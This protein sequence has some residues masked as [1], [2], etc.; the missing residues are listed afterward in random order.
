[1][2]LPTPAPLPRIG[3]RGFLLALAPLTRLLRAQQSPPTFSS[4]VKVVNVLATARDKKGQ[5]VTDLKQEEFHLADDGQPQTIRYFAREIDLPLTLG[6]LVDTS[7][8]QRRVLGQERTAS[9]RFLDQV[10]RESK[11]L[12]FVIHFDREAE[13]LQDLTSSRKQ[14]EDALAQLE[15]PQQ[16][17]PQ[18]NRRGSGGGGG[19]PGGGGGYPGGG[20]G[21][22]GYPGGGGGRGGR[23][24]RGPGTVLYDSVLLAS[25]ELMRK[26]HG[27]KALILLTDGVDNGSKVTLERGIEAAQ[28]A[29][30][31]GGMGRGGGYDRPDGK[32]VL[33]R[34]A[35]ETGGGFFQVS[36]KR[37]IDDIYKQIQ[38]EL[39]SQY[40]LGYTPEPASSNAYFHKI[41]LTTTR[42]EV[43]LQARE[44][45][46]PP[47]THDK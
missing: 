2:R 10:L 24:S 15:L 30:R 35:R 4:D 37:P 31:R 40:N 12:A 19:Y 21:G 25:D 20:G 6:L 22:G 7:M 5:I 47:P 38:E 43:V 8:S 32:K 45:Y 26:Q 44:G 14:L 23:G 3:R 27:R 9:Y 16:D 42:K 18:L 33:E 34:L 39:R 41:A 28:R 36:K 29:G 1:M 46:Y 11:D 17:Q 13:L